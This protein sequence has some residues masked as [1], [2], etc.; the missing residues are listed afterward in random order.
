MRTFYTNL[1]FRNFRKVKFYFGI[2]F[3][4]LVTV[5]LNGYLKSNGYSEVS[6]TYPSDGLEQD[7]EGLTNRRHNRNLQHL[8][9]Q[10]LLTGHKKTNLKAK[11]NKKLSI[12]HHLFANKSRLSIENISLNENKTKSE[13]NGATDYIHLNSNEKRNKYIT[14][15]LPQA[16]IIGVK[17][18]GTRALLEFLRAH[19]NVK[20]TGPEPHFF[21]KNYEKGFEWY[22][23]V[24]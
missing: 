11:I 22:R 24:L 2:C 3:L 8:Y 6:L 15:R 20:A 13:G 23:W 18:G 12:T 14:K 9:S 10:E 7:L 19:P 4:F 21:D 5:L 16:I 17:K 1:L